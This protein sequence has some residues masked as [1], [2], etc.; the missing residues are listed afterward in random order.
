M[1][2]HNLM[3]EIVAKVLK[4]MITAMPELEKLEPIHRDD[5]MAIALN[6][7]PPRYTTTTRG[8]VIVKSQVRAQLESDVYRE[9]S[10]AY[11]IVTKSPR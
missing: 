3:E 6:K 5:M 1:A 9:L 2:V 7:L 4:E 10:E 8:E 11:K